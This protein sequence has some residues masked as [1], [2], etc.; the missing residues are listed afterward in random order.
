[1]PMTEKQNQ[2]AAAA[3]LKTAAETPV[4]NEAII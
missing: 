4:I 3:D 1:M 2:E